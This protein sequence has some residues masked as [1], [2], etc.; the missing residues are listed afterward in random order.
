MKP[1]CFQDSDTD[2]PYV[3]GVF[4]QIGVGSRERE[5]RVG[6]EDKAANLSP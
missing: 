3:P 5:S 1:G 4:A 6:E 2:A